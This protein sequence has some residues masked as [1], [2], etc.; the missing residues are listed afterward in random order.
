MGHPE[1]TIQCSNEVH[2]SAP[3]EDCRRSKY[4]TSRVLL[5]TAQRPSQRLEYFERSARAPAGAA[6]LAWPR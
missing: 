2:H 4:S 3:F 6:V 1:S 5:N